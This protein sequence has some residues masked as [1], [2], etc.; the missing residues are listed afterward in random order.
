MGIV[1][2]NMRRIITLGIILRKRGFSKLAFIP[3]QMIK[4]GSLSIEIWQSIRNKLIFNVTF[5]KNCEELTICLNADSTRTA[6]ESNV[7]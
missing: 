5:K 7:K 2:Q 3:V 1:D 6:G 4:S